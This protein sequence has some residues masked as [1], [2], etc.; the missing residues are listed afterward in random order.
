M[1]RKHLSRLQREEEERIWGGLLL[2]VITAPT[3]P[4]GFCLHCCRQ[5]LA[6]VEAWVSQVFSSHTGNLPWLAARVA[7]ALSVHAVL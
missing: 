6:L 4:Q 1:W 2:N 7:A 5:L 3:L